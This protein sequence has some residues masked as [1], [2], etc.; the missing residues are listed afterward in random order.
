[1]RFDHTVVWT[2]DGFETAEFWADILGGRLAG[3]VG[4]DIAL[5]FDN[6]V[7]VR[8]ADIGSSSRDPGIQQQRYAITVSDDDFRTALKLIEQRR[9]RYWADARRT[10]EGNTY[11]HGDHRGFFVLDPNGHLLELMAFTISS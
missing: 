4:W 1:M 5:A 3:R 11:R 6:E 7:T 9:I 8:F 2:A 10:E